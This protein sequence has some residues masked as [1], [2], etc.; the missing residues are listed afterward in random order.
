MRRESLP[1]LGK[2]RLSSP[3]NELVVTASHFRGIYVQVMWMPVVN[4]GKLTP[5]HL[6]L[7]FNTEF[8]GIIT[9]DHMVP[10]VVCFSVMGRDG[11]ADCRVIGTFSSLRINELIDGLERMQL[12]RVDGCCLTQGANKV[13]GVKHLSR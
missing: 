8:S 13:I 3:E 5:N 1:S 2:E 6:A 7:V 10:F 4:L 11:E 12:C 9:V